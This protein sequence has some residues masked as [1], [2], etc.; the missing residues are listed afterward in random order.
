MVYW[1]HYNCPRCT[2]VRTIYQ[3]ELEYVDLSSNY[4]GHY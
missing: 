1:E 2:S 4:I 3:I